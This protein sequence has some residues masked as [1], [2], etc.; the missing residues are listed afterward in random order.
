MSSKNKFEFTTRSTSAYF[1]LYSEVVS[2]YD[3]REE[4]TQT[5]KREEVFGDL[6]SAKNFIDELKVAKKY[7]NIELEYRKKLEI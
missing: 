4:Y 3:Y 5:F 1:V 2:S 6:E 7:K